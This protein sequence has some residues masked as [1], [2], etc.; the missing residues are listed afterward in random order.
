VSLAI[1]DFGTGYSSLSRLREFS[2]DHLKID[3]SFVRELQSDTESRALVTA[4]IKMAQ[5]LG[6]GVI[7]EGVEEFSQLLHLQEEKCDQ[8]QGFLLS[9]PLPAAEAKALL[10]RLKES[11]ET[12]R[13]NRLR[14]LMR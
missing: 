7:A 14:G 8:A 12:S 4:M 1:D 10:Q 5:T 6:L 2:V 9:K 3:R 13:T 11:N